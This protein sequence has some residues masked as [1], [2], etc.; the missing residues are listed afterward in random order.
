MGAEG[1]VVEN[2]WGLL[3]EGGVVKYSL[4]PC[5]LGALAAAALP[6]PAQVSS[7]TS[8]GTGVTLDGACKGAAEWML[9]ARGGCGQA[10]SYYAGLARGL[11]NCSSRCAVVTYLSDREGTC[12]PV[13]K[14]AAC[15]GSVLDLQI[16]SPALLDLEIRPDEDLQ[17]S[18]CADLHVKCSQWASACAATKIGKWVQLNCPRSCGLCVKGPTAGAVLLTAAMLLRMQ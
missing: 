13:Q 12:S 1:A 7:P 8:A 11:E 3:T 2:N 10:A 9:A 5:G 4:E 16:S 6:S 15:A 18:S 14:D 17:T